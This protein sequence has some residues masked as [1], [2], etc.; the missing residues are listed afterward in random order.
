MQTFT[1]ASFETQLLL[2]TQFLISFSIIQSFKFQFKLKTT[3][4]RTMGPTV[5]WKF[6]TLTWKK[7]YAIHGNAAMYSCSKTTYLITNLMK[8]SND[9]K[10]DY[11]DTTFI[12]RSQCQPWTLS[13]TFTFL[14]TTQNVAQVLH[15]SSSN[16]L[17][18]PYYD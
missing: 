14:T 17:L 7:Q 4:V 11:H 12:Q 18:N 1:D 6:R 10:K 8:K 2:F 13:Q 5:V 16:D 9:H 3:L 15:G